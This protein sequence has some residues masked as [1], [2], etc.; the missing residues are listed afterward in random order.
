M[1]TA[2]ELE[3]EWEKKL[4]NGETDSRKGRLAGERDDKGCR[5]EQSVRPKLRRAR[6]YL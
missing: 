2:G 3:S 4:V 5:C 1:E 6:W